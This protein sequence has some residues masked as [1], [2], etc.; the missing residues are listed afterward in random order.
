ML[1][2]LTYIHDMDLLRDLME[3]TRNE[4]WIHMMALSALPRRSDFIRPLPVDVLLLDCTYDTEATLT[5][6]STMHAE[7]KLPFRIVYMVEQRMTQ[8][9]KTIMA[10]DREAIFVYAPFSVGKIM[11]ELMKSSVRN[12]GGIHT[13]DEGI[14]SQLIQDM[15]IPVHLNGFRYIKTAAICLL[16]G[17][18]QKLLM[19]QL[20]K[21]IARIHMTTS[22]RVE[23]AIRDAIDYA[24]RYE[25]DKIQIQHRKPTNSQLIHLIYERMLLQ[26]QET[27]EERKV[28]V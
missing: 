19:H 2:I 26:Q 8:T 9:I 1:R 17:E 6:L 4:P 14:V 18:D 5:F 20:Y 7:E 3:L 11:M 28:D 13:N 23:K 27:R 21:E 24:Y 22:S 16:H 25:P 10:Q 12:Q 15:G